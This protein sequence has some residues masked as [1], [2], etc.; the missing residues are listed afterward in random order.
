[1]AVL[2]WIQYIY[3]LIFG[4][5]KW[6]GFFLQPVLKYA[7]DI[8]VLCCSTSRLVPPTSLTNIKLIVI[9]LLFLLRQVV[10]GALVYMACRN[11]DKASQAREDILRENPR[12]NL[13]LVRLDLASLKSVRECADSFL[14]GWWQII[15]AY[16][17]IANSQV[18]ADSSS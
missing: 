10:A 5:A 9:R 3:C 1:M 7:F 2:N 13:K 6:D 14:K 18:L 4:C 12:A 17:C 15:L 16:L 11:M 8:V